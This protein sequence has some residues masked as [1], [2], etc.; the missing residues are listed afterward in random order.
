M[1]EV[2]VL[3]PLVFWTLFLGVYPQPFLSRVEVSINHHIA[4]I[5]SKEIGFTKDDLTKSGFIEGI[6]WKLVEY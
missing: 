4:L 2:I 5:K 6:G 1:R 3:I